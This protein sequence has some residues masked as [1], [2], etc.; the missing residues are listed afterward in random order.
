MCLWH[1]R[2]HVCRYLHR[3]HAVVGICNKWLD[4]FIKTGLNTI[5]I[6]AGPDAGYMICPLALLPCH[7]SHTQRHFA[8][9]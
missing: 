3:Q 1:Y 6:L 2:N 5:P 7:G 8:Q 4:P 9:Q